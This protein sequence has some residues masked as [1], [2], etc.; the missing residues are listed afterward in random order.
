MWLEVNQSPTKS[1]TN[2]H[3]YVC[4]C[5][6]LAA[7]VHTLFPQTPNLSYSINFRWKANC[8]ELDHF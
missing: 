1:R 4:V 7:Q 5:T 6:V 3:T 8:L 2:N